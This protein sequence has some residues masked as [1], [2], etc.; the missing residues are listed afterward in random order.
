LGVAI[1]PETGAGNC[2][3]VDPSRQRDV[4]SEQKTYEKICRNWQKADSGRPSKRWVGDEIVCLLAGPI[5]QVQKYPQSSSVGWFDDMRKV[6]FL[7]DIFGEQAAEFKRQQLDRAV[8]LVSKHGDAVQRVANELAERHT[9][10]GE[11]VRGFFCL[12]NALMR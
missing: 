9:L 10:A 7:A 6:E 4:G 5:A 2:F 11:E 12:D 3:A 1:N 8:A